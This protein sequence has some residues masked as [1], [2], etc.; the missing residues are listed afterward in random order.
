MNAPA[1]NA[2]NPASLGKVAVLMGGF[3]AEREISLM[4]GSGVLE[5]LRSRGVDAHAFDPANRPWTTSSA[6]DF[7]VAS[8][9][10]M[11][12]L[13]RMARCRVPWS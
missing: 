2:V 4:S 1:S 12:V 7:R 3:S 6:K 11:D 5:A 10:C 13:G 8:L 9:P